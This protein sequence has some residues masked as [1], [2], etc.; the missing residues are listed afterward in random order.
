M[1]IQTDDQGR[2]WCEWL[3][4]WISPKGCVARFRLANTGKSKRLR[5]SPCGR[6]CNVG[7][8]LDA[9]KPLPDGFAIEKREAPPTVASR[10]KAWGYAVCQYDGC[11]RQGKPYKKHSGNHL[12]FC[13][14]SCAKRAYRPY[15]PPTPGLAELHAVMEGY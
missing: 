15:R 14:R 3:R 1:P 7:C 2:F 5:E 9:G 8:A 6:S 12:N 11:P 10:D 4:C 13:S